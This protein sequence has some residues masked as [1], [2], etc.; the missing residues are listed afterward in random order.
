MTALWIMSAAALLIL[1]TRPTAAA[2]EAAVL[3]STEE[4]VETPALESAP[5]PSAQARQPS[6]EAAGAMGRYRKDCHH[7]AHGHHAEIDHATGGHGRMGHGGHSGAMHH[8]MGRRMDLLQA[9]VEQ[10]EGRLR[11]IEKRLDLLQAMQH[12]ERPELGC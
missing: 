12:R 1:G 10:M 8:H 7:G 6:F 4:T 11:Q 5:A 2:P 3:P 9:L